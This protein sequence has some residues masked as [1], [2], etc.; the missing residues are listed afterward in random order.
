MKSLKK[1]LAVLIVVTIMAGIIA[2]PVLAASLN[3]EEEASVL[4]Q[5]DLFR[6]KSETE[7]QPALEDRLLR[8][9]AVALLLRMFGLEEEA[10]A[11]TDKEANDLLAKFADAGEIAEWARKHVAYAVK[12]EIVVGRPD[13]KFAPKDNLIGREYAKMVLALLGYVQ[14]TDFEYKFSSVEFA[15]KTGFSQSEAAEFDEAILI[16]DNVVGMSF[17]AL[18]A[19]Y[20][21]GPNAGKTVIEVIVGDDEDLKAIAIEAGLLEEAVIVEVAALD[22]IVIKVGEKLNLPAKV[23]ATY[24]DGAEADVAVVW[25]AVDNSKAMAKTEITGKIADTDVVAKINVTIE[26]D[27]LLVDSVTAGN[28]VE[29]VVVYNQD[30]SGNAAVASKDNYSLSLGTIASVSVDG[31]TAVLSL[32]TTKKLPN[33][34]TPAKLTVKDKILGAAETFELTY[35]DTTLPEVLG[36]EAT[37]PKE[38]TITFSEPIKGKGN[39]TVKSGTSTLS[40]DTNRIVLGTSKVTVPLYSTLVD[41]KEYVISISEFKDYA[42]YN[43]VIKTITYAYAKDTTAPVA[44][45]E[46]ATQEY[47]VVKFNKPVSGIVKEQFSHTFSAYIASK[48]TSDADGKTNIVPATSYDKVYVWFYTSNKAIDKPIPEGDISFRIL[49]KQAVSGTDYEIKDLWGNKFETASFTVSIT[50]DKTAPEVKEVKVTAENAISIEFTKK[51]SFDKD[52]FEVLDSDGKAIDGLTFT[53]GAITDNKYPV[54]FNK[55]LAGKTIIVNI[56]NVYDATLNSNKLDLYSV[57]LDVTDKTKPKVTEVDLDQTNKVLYVFYDEDIDEATGLNIGNYYLKNGDEY[58]KLSKTPTFF[59]G[60]KI[61][62]IPL[63]DAEYGKIIPAST[64]LFI[65][66]VKDAAGNEIL[67]TVTGN[68]IIIANKKPLMD[69]ANATALNT[70][71]LYFKEQMGL[72]DKEAFEVAGISDV[73]IA[74]MEEQ[75]SGGKTKLILTLDKDMPYDAVGVTVKIKDG[76][77]LKNLFDVSPDNATI[78]VTDKIAPLLDGDPVQ[79]VANDESQ[80]KL[81]FKENMKTSNAAYTVTDFVVTAGD[82]VLQAGNDYT[83]SISGKVITIQLEGKYAAYR[84]KLKIKYVNK[85]LNYVSDIAGNKMAEFSK[86]ITMV[87]RSYGVEQDSGTGGTG[88]NYAFDKGVLNI[89]M[90][91]GGEAVP[92]VVNPPAYGSE[93]AYWLGVKIAAPVTVGTIDDAYDIEVTIDGAT[94]PA[95]TNKDFNDG[96]YFYPSAGK[97]KKE[98]AAAGKEN[99]KGSTTIKIKWSESYTETIIINYDV[100]VVVYKQAT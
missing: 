88:L 94:T 39:I 8:E 5:L 80:I 3:Y 19:E 18:Q 11:M 41:G 17:N 95:K 69:K 61:V 97:T 25:D 31:N 54:T 33:N 75:L 92:F 82:T 50:A 29:V 74:S 76:S 86:E 93:G 21:A 65:T 34:Q 36:L 96:F 2:V 35:F 71:E 47:V 15:N 59:E 27:A 64:T 90:L 43:N 56:K 30:V 51:V 81:T 60:S 83:A 72:V 89:S 38:F 23:K 66:G 44:E 62:K 40:V 77:L 1:L 4:N 79:D 73:T 46:K 37:G 16:R 91:E 85:D 68:F 10:K 7:Y 49:G 63:A 26:V 45:I 48:V 70:I 99:V 42:D 55:G 98:A 52:N 20:F 78:G 57:T 100:D 67:P 13:G 28:L 53:I 84:G 6:G 32:D 87:D 14:G 24:S 22:D 12:N 58:T 9:E